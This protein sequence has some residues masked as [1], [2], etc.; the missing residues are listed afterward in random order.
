MKELQKGLFFTTLL[1][2]ALVSLYML[3]LPT[4]NNI[5][6]IVNYPSSRLKVQSLYI[7]GSSCGLSWTKGYQLTNKGNNTW[8]YS[9]TCPTDTVISIKILENDSNSM[10]GKNFEFLISIYETV[11]SVNVYP[12]FYPSIN[13]IVDTNPVESSILNNSRKCSIY[14]PPSY[15]DNT[16][17]TYPLL[18][19][20]DGQNLFF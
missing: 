10:M 3:N 1:G 7:R 18:L 4:A 14:Y 16:Y 19:M 9:L 8:T 15:H 13:P 2:I 17:K 20:H 6:I 11:K 5:Q 12:S